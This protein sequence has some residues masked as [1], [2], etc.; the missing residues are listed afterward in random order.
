MYVMVTNGGGWYDKKEG[1]VFKVESTSFADRWHYVDVEIGTRRF[2][3]FDNCVEIDLPYGVTVNNGTGYI[4]YAGDDY[5]LIKRD[6]IVGDLV[7]FTKFDGEAVACIR[8]VVG[9]SAVDGDFYL[10]EGI[11]DETYVD[12]DLDKYYVLVA[13]GSKHKFEEPEDTHEP[14]LAYEPMDMLPDEPDTVNHPNHYTTGKFE[15]I[16]MI[17]EVTKGYED[18]FV[19][20]T[21]G[22]VQKY[23]ARAPHKGK[24]IEDLEKARKYLDFALDYLEKERAE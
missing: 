6:A 10:D 16:E 4:N 15:V 13:A 12:G 19:G 17:E 11:N 9:T 8:E 1:H 23:I 5:Y 24:L 22:N 3:R 20:Y 18:P 21:I 7:L 2:V 14:D